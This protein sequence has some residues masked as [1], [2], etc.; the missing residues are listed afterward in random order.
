MPETTKVP[1]PK[2]PQVEKITSIQQLMPMARVLVSRKSVNMFE[3]WDIKQG[4]KVLFIN[5]DTS[6]QMVLE[7]LAAAAREKGAHVTV[8]TLEDRTDPKDPVEILD[9]MFSN[10][11]FP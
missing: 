7:A 6:D 8:I 9:N 1:S 11:W 5:D 3:G 10:N 4:Q 2:M